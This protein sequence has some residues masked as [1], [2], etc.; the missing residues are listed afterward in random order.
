MA[1]P[2]RNLGYKNN[3]PATKPSTKKTTTTAATITTARPS[4]AIESNPSR[5]DS[6]RGRTV[7]PSPR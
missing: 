3:R 5:A 4:G 6:S 2:A 1:G 7:I